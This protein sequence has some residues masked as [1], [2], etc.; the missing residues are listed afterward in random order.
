MKERV[1]KPVLKGE[2]CIALCITEATAGSDMAGLQTSAEK[3]VENGKEYYVINGQKKVSLDI[4]IYFMTAK[5][6]RYLT[7][8]VSSGL[9]KQSMLI[10]SLL[11]FALEELGTAE[12]LWCS[13]RG[14]L[15]AFR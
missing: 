4:F 3:I 13:L 1:V 14:T 10:S 8:R 7:P 6:V 2:K 9:L 5:T 12:Y 15:L 11:R